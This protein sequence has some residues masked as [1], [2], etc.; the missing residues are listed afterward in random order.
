MSDT[1]AGKLG[2]NAIES[3][4]DSLNSMYQR[5]ALMNRE[6]KARTNALDLA[7]RFLQETSPT[8]RAN[9]VINAAELFADY[10]LNGVI[11]TERTG[12]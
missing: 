9:N 4:I 8:Y 5:Q 3:A 12:L 2:F 7:L 6:A 11:A 1:D 10:V